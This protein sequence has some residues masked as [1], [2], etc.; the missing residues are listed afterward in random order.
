MLGS[1]AG[2]HFVALLV[3]WTLLSPLFTGYSALFPLPEHPL[4]L[5]ISL[6]YVNNGSKDWLINESFRSF[7]MFINDSCQT[8]FFSSLSSVQKVFEDADGNKY[9]VLGEDVVLHPGESLLFSVSYRVELREREIPPF[10]R[11]GNLSDVPSDLADRY[12]KPSGPWRYDEGGAWNNLT[13][14]AQ[15]LTRGKSNALEALYALASW[16]K[17]NVLYQVHELPLYPNETFL[18]REGDCDDLANLL[19]ALCR[20]VGLPAYLELGFI[21]YPSHEESSAA[22]NGSVLIESENIAWHGWAMVYLPNVGWVP[23]DFFAYSPDVDNSTLIVRS[24]L[25]YA[26][27]VRCIKIVNE[28]YV[29]SYRNYRDFLL[30]NG[31][32]LEERFSLRE[33]VPPPWYVELLSSFWFRVSCATASAI[34]IIVLVVAWRKCRKRALEVS[35]LPS[36]SPSPS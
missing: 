28:D 30:K 4:L 10:Q 17:R 3:L 25:Y 14:L 33:L 9:A 13:E 16:V 21:Y 32:R 2:R 29:L 7:E 27:A 8:I 5:E 1:F 18:K 22:W 31:Y 11:A 12:C 23:A 36:S 35:R 34:V 20:M 15:N 24:A 6:R 26:H 19:I